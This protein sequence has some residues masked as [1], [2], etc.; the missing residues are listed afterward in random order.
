MG[1][2]AILSCDLDDLNIFFFSWPKEALG[3]IWLKLALWLSWRCSK[4]TYYESPWSK[5]KNDLDLFY[6]QIF[7]NYLLRF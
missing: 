4:L 7:M 1:L 6:L 5:V 2:V 3:G